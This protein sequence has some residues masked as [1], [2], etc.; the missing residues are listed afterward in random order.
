MMTVA[1]RLKWRWSGPFA[2]TG[3]MSPLVRRVHGAGMGSLQGAAFPVLLLSSTTCV[4]S[5]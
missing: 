3:S 1:M 4:G 2:V 5:I